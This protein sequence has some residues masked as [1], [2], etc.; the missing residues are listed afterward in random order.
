MNMLYYYYRQNARVLTYFCPSTFTSI[1]PKDGWT[2]LW[3]SP[4]L[5]ARLKLGINCLKEGGYLR[6]GL[7]CLLV[8]EKYLVMRFLRSNAHIS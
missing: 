1:R 3:L 8:G 4:C 7:N 5:L 6:R 2:G